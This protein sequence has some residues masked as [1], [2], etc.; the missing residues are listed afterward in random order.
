MS[1]GDSNGNDSAPDLIMIPEGPRQQSS[2]RLSLLVRK[3]SK[4]GEDGA[5]R[6]TKLATM[7]T[8]TRRHPPN[9]HSQ[10]I[11]GPALAGKEAKMLHSRIPRKNGCFMVLSQYHIQLIGS[12]VTSPKSVTYSRK[13]SLRHLKT[14][15]RISSSHSL[16]MRLHQLIA[17]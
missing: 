4:T 14:L 7:T 10:R 5:A 3:K 9:T 2:T 17:L 8:T 12:A 15:G 1:G 6:F 16:T 13:E 11:K